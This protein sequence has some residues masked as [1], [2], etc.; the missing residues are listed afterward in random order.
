MSDEQQIA[1][2]REEVRRAG[3]STQT[4]RWIMGG[5]VS[6][7][8]AAVALTGLVFAALYG[9]WG[10]VV[11]GFLCAAISGTVMIAAAALSVGALC[12]F[13]YS[14]RIARWLAE[15]PSSVRV[16]VLQPLLRDP[17]GDTRN[18]ADWLL[19]EFGVPAE[20]APASAPDACG[21]EASPAE[22]AE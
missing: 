12:H 1:A 9:G 11:T 22:V 19:T 2:L 5:V 18:I 17:L 8:A 6:I 16:D 14:R 15:K 20:L 10:G 7:P 13:Y 21:D 4:A 3:R